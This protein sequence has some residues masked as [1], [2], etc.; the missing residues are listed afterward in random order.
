MFPAAFMVKSTLTVL[1]VL[2]ATVDVQIVPSSE[3]PYLPGQ[4]VD[5]EIR[6]VQTDE[7][8]SDH[9]LRLIQFDFGSTVNDAFV[10]TPAPTH[11]VAGIVGWDFGS[12]STCAT[13]PADCGVGHFIDDQFVGPGALPPDLLTLAYYFVDADDLGPNPEAQLN[14]SV[15]EPLTVMRLELTMPDV[16]G[17][18][19]LDVVNEVNQ[20]PNRGGIVYYGFGLEPDDPVVIL[21]P[22]NAAPDD[23]T[24]GTRVFVVI[25]ENQAELVSSMPVCNTGATPM[26]TWW[27]SS[28]NSALLAFDIDIA[29]PL[30]GDV[31]VVEL[32]PDG[33]LGE[34]VTGQFVFA[35]EPDS[36]GQPRT[37]RV[38][39]TGAVAPEG[40]ANGVLEHQ[41]WYTIINQGDWLGA[42]PFNIDLVVQAGD[43]NGDGRVNSLDVSAINGNDPFPCLNRRLCADL[44]ADVNGDNRVN[45]LDVST[46]NGRMGLGV[47]TAPKPSGHTCG[48]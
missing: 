9:L 3:G 18:Y 32:L 12:T 42:N 38:H 5:A 26:G 39:Q 13:N 29:P 17:R 2:P 8:T 31:Q 34:D 7:A 35:V 14:L 40:T 16:P 4:V 45:S 30:P 25:G 46:L 28:H 6:V 41:K 36:S 22:N 20:D 11:P 10:T 43:V 23:L 15:S 48:P 33:D 47:A 44:R 37:L 24:G 19:T 27:R 1:G 21:R